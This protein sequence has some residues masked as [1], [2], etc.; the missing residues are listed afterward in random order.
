L[1]NPVNLTMGQTS[2]S[3]GEDA[4]SLRAMRLLFSVLLFVVAFLPR[5]IRPVS[6]PLVWY[7]RSAYFIEDVLSNH[8]AGTV[9]SEHPGVT[10]M[11]PAGIGLKLYWAISGIQPAAH[12]LPPGFEPIH[13]FGPVPLSEIT[14][15]LVPVA[16]LIALGIV[17]A[18]LMLQRLFDSATGIVAG[19]LL[20]LSPYYLA[21]SKVLHLDA[22]MATL[23]LL[24]AL[25]ML[26]YRR[27]RRWRWLLFS[28]SL[29]GLALLTKIP[30][31]FLVPFL[32]LVLLVDLLAGSEHVLRDLGRS[33][34]MPISIWLLTVAAVYVAVWP[35]MWV[36]PGKGLAAVRWGITRHGTTAHD[37]P[38]LFLGQVTG[39]DPG[40]VFYVISLLF[41]SS[42]ITLTFL[43]VGATLGIILLLRRR[44]ASAA[45]AERQA[46]AP[47]DLLLLLAYAVAY[48]AQMSLGAKKM[49]RYILPS[50]LALNILAAAGVV[51]WARALG[52]KRRKTRIALMVL[53]VLM[54]A[55]LT[56]PRHPYYGTALNWVSGGPPAAAEALLIGE[57]GEGYA[58]LAGYLNAKPG[59]RELTV[60]AQLMHVFNQTF[61]G[62]TVELVQATAAA[63]GSTDY[64]AFHRNYT[65]R[66]YKIKEWG[67][68]WERY[69]ARTPE[70]EISFD[71]VSYA[72]LYPKLTPDVAPEHN[73]EIRFG[74]QFTLLGYDLRR[75][76]V[77]PG[78][79]VS[80]VLYWQATEPVTEDLSIFVHLL[81]LRGE[82]IWQDDGAAD[83]GERPTWS[84]PPGETIVDPHT[85]RL[86][87]DLAEGEYLLTVGLYDWQTGDRLSVR[88][89]RGVQLP[90]NKVTV[91]SLSVKRAHIA[92][93]AWLARA[94]AM[95]AL[96]AGLVG[97]LK[98]HRP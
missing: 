10:L 81:D 47:L 79:E 19:L 51:A 69:A 54:Q 82:L 20:A 33:L 97:Q 44:L 62:T 28:A 68:L 9:Y 96:I 75:T 5:A 92:P 14:A 49:P 60:A 56:L 98:S 30:A 95:F 57:E 17:A 43:V 80:V 25:A 87:P 24:S 35:V 2:K 21:Q 40:P 74:D 29:A 8:W 84:W 89:S 90:E 59:A 71:A 4:A 61:R 83:H 1:A 42:E 65:S 23:M 77:E 53:P 48:L 55:V 78:D 15:A 7:V 37:S 11:W 18:Y 36:D 39:E 85:V 73:E 64:V 22:L 63:S 91:T 88:D 72:W 50:L 27:E 76:E 16:L 93:M 46:Q 94:L 31:L 41:R 32:G 3:A 6:R 70:R 67:P 13:F 66:D 12:T 34:L 86:P 45:S 38:T 26:I 58:E 52:G